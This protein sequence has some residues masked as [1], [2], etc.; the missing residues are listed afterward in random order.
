M[1][2][3]LAQVVLE[4]AGQEE[5]EAEQVVLVEGLVAGQLQQIRLATQLAEQQVE[6]LAMGRQTPREIPME[7]TPAHRTTLRMEPTLTRIRTPSGASVANQK[8]ARMEPAR[9]VLCLRWAFN[10][11]EILY[12]PGKYHKHMSTY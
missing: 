10:R 8:K 9:W 4:V 3:L 7:S 1:E 11:Q 12:I 6:A 2:E 5:E